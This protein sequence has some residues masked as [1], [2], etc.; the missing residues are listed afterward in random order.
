M[1]QKGL[2]EG[3]FCVQ[4]LSLT[5]APNPD[6]KDPKSSKT[7]RK[8]GTNHVITTNLGCVEC[9]VL[10]MLRTSKKHFASDPL[11]GWPSTGKTFAKEVQLMDLW[12]RRK[13]FC[14][15]VANIFRNI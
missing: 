4:G 1:A 2:L 14:C 9:F 13:A 3:F 11:W 12:I 6:W 10:G 8:R 7:K 5:V 15:L